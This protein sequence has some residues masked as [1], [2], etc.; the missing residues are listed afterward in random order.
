M[1]E[2]KSKT[3]TVNA[4]NVSLFNRITDLN[5]LYASIPEDKRKDVIID[6]DTVKASY[7]GFTIAVCISKKLP[8]SLVEISDV[9]APFHFRISINL[10]SA[11]IISQTLLDI[12]VDA[13]LNFMM[14]A[15]LGSKIQEYLDKF[16]DAVANGG[17]LAE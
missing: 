5:G 4:S 13:D 14:K 9:E 11:E 17:V 2:Y 7:A 8:F 16:V 12:S 10:R 6:G 3:V 1:A 15:L